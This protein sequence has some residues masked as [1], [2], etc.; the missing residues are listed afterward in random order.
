M[1]L[2]SRKH[3]YSLP[4]DLYFYFSHFFQSIP[5]WFPKAQVLV[6]LASSV[7]I[8]FWSKVAAQVVR[9]SDPSRSTGLDFSPA[10]FSVRTQRSQP[11][12]ELIWR[13]IRY[14][15][16][17]DMYP[18]CIHLHALWTERHSDANAFWRREDNEHGLLRY[19]STKQSRGD[20]PQ[21]KRQ[22]S[23]S[24]S[25]NHITWATKVSDFLTKRGIS[26]ENR[27]SMC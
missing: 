26:Q 16:T 11:S 9:N 21:D 24:S 3:L 27:P 2:N 25:T 17:P 19:P 14:D 20:L 12:T 6:C 13:T 10:A 8:F 18:V 7:R 4:S 1:L 5:K 23:D 22:K 15:S